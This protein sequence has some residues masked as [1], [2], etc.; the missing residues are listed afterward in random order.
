MAVTRASR[1]RYV[2]SSEHKALPIDDSYAL[3][4]AAYKRS[5]ASRCDPTITRDQAEE[6]LR[7]ARPLT[8]GRW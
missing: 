8:P 7:A 2:G 4:P 3:E 6:A 1:A 5:D